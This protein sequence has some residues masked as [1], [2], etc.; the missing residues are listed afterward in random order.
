M[1][2]NR[3]TPQSKTNNIPNLLIYSEKCGTCN[4]FITMCHKNKILSSF[5]MINIDDKMQLMIEKGFK[6]VP[7]IIVR[8]I[9]KPIEGRDV[10][11]W[12]ESVLSMM[13]NKKFI[14][15]DQYLPETG[16]QQQNNN[17]MMMQPGF[18]NINSNPMNNNVVKRST[19]CQPP[20][21][22]AA[23]NGNGNGN[24]I[25]NNTVTNNNATN[26]NTVTN[27]N[28]TNNNTVNNTV[29]NNGINNTTGPSVKSQPHGFL[30]DEMLGFSD[31]FAYLMTDNPLPKSFLPFDKD[32][33]IY[34]APEGNRLDKRQQ[35]KI[36]KDIE[37]VRS[38]D[39][40][41]FIRTI[42]HE[43]QQIITNHQNQQHQ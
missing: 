34:T 7:T 24:R 6:K 21:V 19:M 15:E 25:N 22:I 4:T 42:E 2:N 37:S 12:L 14:T 31:S 18:T 33:Q 1:N 41:A 9:S 30:Q 10:F 38:N 26:N 23:N 27:N 39:R 13:N 5:Q 40:D 17:T 32:L 8:G 28:A 36:I 3:T 16:I 11:Q 43:H 20:P 35:D 29:N